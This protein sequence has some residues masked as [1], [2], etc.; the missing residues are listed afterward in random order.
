MTP[1]GCRRWSKWNLTFPLWLGYAERCTASSY[2]V[3]EVEDGLECWSNSGPL[4]LITRSCCLN[5]VCVRQNCNFTFIGSK[6]SQQLNF[7]S[8][9]KFSQTVCSLRN[10]TWSSI[11]EP[12][13]NVGCIMWAGYPEG[14]GINRFHNN[15]KWK[16][17]VSAT[18]LRL[19]YAV[20]RR[21]AERANLM[22]GRMCNTV[23]L[24]TSSLFC[25]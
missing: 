2:I 21:Y 16:Q 18:L 14:H 10:F 11:I 1:L 22:A 8:K 20:Y 24:K 19:L 4:W 12:Q 5:E 3:I 13:E 15:A 25:S 17:F 6:I 7:V 23:S 9:M